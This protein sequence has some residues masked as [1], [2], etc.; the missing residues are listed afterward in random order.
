MRNTTRNLKNRRRK[1]KIHSRLAQHSKQQKKA[2]KAGA[3]AP[4]LVAGAASAL[5]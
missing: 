4:T 1:Q 3:S 2:Q 5:L